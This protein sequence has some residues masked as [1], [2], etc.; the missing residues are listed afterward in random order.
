MVTYGDE[1][2]MR[3]DSG[4][5]GRRPMPWETGPRDAQ[6]WDERILDVYR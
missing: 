1:I 3:G 6:P 2:G 4:E 5:D